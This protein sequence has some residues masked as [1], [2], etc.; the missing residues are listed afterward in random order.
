MICSLLIWF[1]FF[2]QTLDYVKCASNSTLKWFFESQCRSCG[3]SCDQIKI[4]AAADG[5]RATLFINK[6]EIVWIQIQKGI[7]SQQSV[8]VTCQPVILL[9]NSTWINIFA[10]NFNLNILNRASDTKGSKTGLWTSFLHS[11]PLLFNLYICTYILL[12][13]SEAKK[14]INIPFFLVYDSDPR[15]FFAKKKRSFLFPGKTTDLLER[16]NSNTS[17]GLVLNG[18]FWKEIKHIFGLD[19][20]LTRS[21]ITHTRP[22]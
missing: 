19:H 11:F 21:I 16:L 9:E 13:L 15:N 3:T 5:Y 1:I 22:Y 18:I 14:T 2:L 7:F 8:L 4:C 17:S 10:S 20:L 6:S 12:Y